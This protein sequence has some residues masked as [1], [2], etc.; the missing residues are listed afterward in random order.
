MSERSET[1]LER[2]SGILRVDIVQHGPLRPENETLDVPVPTDPHHVDNHQAIVYRRHRMLVGETHSP[3]RQCWL[4]WRAV[5][6]ER[7][8]LVTP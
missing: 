8:W 5:H 1:E 7:P 3:L 6:L 4:G 2:R